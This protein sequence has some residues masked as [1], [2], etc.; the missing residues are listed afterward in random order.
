MTE[1]RLGAGRPYPMGAHADGNGVNF[2]VF[3]AHAE[4][5]DV[6]LFDENGKEQRFR[7]PEKSGDVFHGH[8]SGIGAGQ[9]YGYRADGAGAY[10]NPAKLL[11]DP[12]TRQVDGTVYLRTAAERALFDPADRQD[13]AAA[14]PKSVVV[15]D[16]RFDWGDDRHP[17]TP[18][19]QTMIYEAH[20]K[21]LTRLFPDLADA[22]TYRALADPRLIAH[23]QALGITAVELL[24][25]QQHADEYRLQTAGLTNYWGY[26]TL[27]HFAVEPTYATRPEQA[28]DELRQAVK[29]LHAA[30]I[31]VILDV[32]YNHTAE[33]DE[34]GAMLCQRG[35]DNASWYWTDENG[36]YINWS[37]CGNTLNTACRDVARWLADSLRYWVQSFHIDGFRF[38]LATILGREPDFQAAGRLLN[39]LYQDPIL[40]PRKL[41]A[42]AW[43]LSGE[44]MGAF[45]PP[46]AEW[47]G[48][49]RDDIRRFWLWE[50]GDL[51]RLAERLA[52]SSDLFRRHGRRPSASVNFLTAHDGFTLHDLTAYN[53]KH[54]EANGENNRDGHH[55]N[56]SYNHG[57][58]GASSD[59]DILRLR[60]HSAKALLATLFL[61]NGTPMLLAG[62][63]FGNSQYGNNN[64]YCQD[65]ET[66]WL[67]WAAFDREL[68]DYAVSLSALRRQIPVFA[69]DNWFDGSNVR[70]LNVYGSA[71]GEDDW[72]DREVK[73]MQV[74]LD[75]DWLLLING[76]RR[77]Q[78][79]RLPEGN[80]QCRSAPNEDYSH[81]G[82]ECLVRQMGIWLFHNVY[83]NGEPQ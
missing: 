20:V 21:G 39:I 33:Q 45:L 76:K 57:C 56:I 46:F 27:A 5:I 10:F 51:G 7:L 82:A 54:N 34:S 35:L 2:A 63:E 13:N 48:R 79:F 80:W 49:F 71:M 15:A 83:S 43:D 24:P 25:V 4:W 19:A 74:V 31:E 26:N 12:Y 81:T 16:S 28:A 77:E 3:S 37:G 69:R 17:D 65:N 38:D 22:G 50:S 23:L 78:T 55:D 32:V 1:R 11:L 36:G 6:C 18:W 67:D 14:A 72:H 9:R 8:I 59:A 60:R 66:A 62:D 42:E 75:N 41:I 40:A 44:Q 64:A 61:A 68:F 30:G 29:A 53:E 52:G 70:W 58:E 73:A 47:N